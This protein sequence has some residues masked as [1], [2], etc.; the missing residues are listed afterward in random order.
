MVM[1]VMERCSGC[2]D[3][4]MLTLRSA[5]EPPFQ[6]LAFASLGWSRL[7]S[8]VGASLFENASSNSS[9]S[10]GLFFFP[11]DERS[12]AAS[13]GSSPSLLR[14][15]RSAFAAASRNLQGLGIQL[16]GLW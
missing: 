1:I 11:F 3:P 8:R 2:A 16:F 7:A 9:D 14:G 5:A 15:R 13:S 12:Q 4:L 6:I 10:Q